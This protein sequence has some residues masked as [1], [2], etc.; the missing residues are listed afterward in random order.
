MKN[1]A[2]F[3]PGG[4]VCPFVGRNDDAYRG[5]ACAPPNPGVPGCGGC[6][7]GLTLP[8]ALAA[9]FSA[10]SETGCTAT[11]SVACGPAFNAKAA[12]VDAVAASASR[13]TKFAAAGQKPNAIQVNIAA[14]APFSADT[15][16][17]P[18]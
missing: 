16:A 5:A 3:A 11:C 14:V 4:I 2:R 8:D 12:D 1:A 17:T 15:A 9:S 13:P 10:A 7:I 18:N 6:C